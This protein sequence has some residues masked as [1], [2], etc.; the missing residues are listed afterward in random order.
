MMDVYIMGY[1]FH[2]AGLDKNFNL[3]TIMTLIQL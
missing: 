1:F 3:N 2:G